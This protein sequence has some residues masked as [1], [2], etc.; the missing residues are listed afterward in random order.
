MM[1]LTRKATGIS[2]TAILVGIAIVLA[3][4]I[5]ADA[6]PVSRNAGRGA[7]VGG[8]IGAITGNSVLEGA[9]IG[10]G[11]GAIIGSAKK[12]RYRRDRRRYHRHHRNRGNRGRGRGRRGRW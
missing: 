11:A 8:A 1:I 4:P 2:I 6:G 7:L 10:A 9:A 12:Q 3:I 5:A